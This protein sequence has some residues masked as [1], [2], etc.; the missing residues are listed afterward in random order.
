MGILD[1][2]KNIIAEQAVKSYLNKYGEVKK[3]DINLSKRTFD[4]ELLLKGEVQPFTL[5]VSSMEIIEDRDDIF[6]KVTRMT[7][8]REWVNMILKDF[9]I[10]KKF[11]VPEQYKSYVK[12]IM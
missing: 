11:S 6:I 8:S 5:S 12:M 1:G 10:G 3:I 2:P 4:A 9:V 7:A